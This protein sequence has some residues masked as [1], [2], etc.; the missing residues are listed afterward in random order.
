MRGLSLLH[1]NKSTRQLHPHANT[2]KRDI[3]I[4]KTYQKTSCFY[5]PFLNLKTHSMILCFSSSGLGHAFSFFV[6]LE[7]HEKMILIPNATYY[8][9]TQG[10]FMFPSKPLSHKKFLRVYLEWKFFK[11]AFNFFEQY[12][13]CRP[14]KAI[15]SQ[16]P[17]EKLYSNILKHY[18][19]RL[20][21]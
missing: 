13:A 14:I 17:L 12:E 8:T 10:Q 20:Q 1:I 5:K 6:G 2:K 21:F 11:K 15:P 3:S 4:P 18:A 19:N 16:L 7:H 9:F